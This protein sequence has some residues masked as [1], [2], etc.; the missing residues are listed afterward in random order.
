MV[1][2]SGLVV[3][4]ALLPTAVPGTGSVEAGVAVPMSARSWLAVGQTLDQRV[5]EL[6]SALTLDEEVRL[7]YGVAAPPSSAPAGY[8]RGVERL[9][10]PPLVLSDGPLGLR[11]STRAA[12]R[13]P[14]TALPAGLSLSASFDRSL[15]GAY[16][17]VLGGEARARGVHVLYGPAINIVRH[18]LGGRN[19]EYLGEDPYLAGELAVPYVQG[20]QSHQVAA[21][22]KHFALN[23][24]ENGRHALSS[25]ADERTVREIYLPAF[26]AAVRRGGA[27]SLMCA[28]N[29]IN[30]V[31][32]CE[33]ARLLRDV[34]EGEWGFDGVVGSDYA[35]THSA[36]GSVNAGLDQSFSWRDWGAFYRDLPGLVR[37]GKVARS[38]VDGRVRRIL[39][40]MFRIGMFDPPA[41]VPPVVDV[42]ANLRVARRT[43]EEGMVLLRNDRRLLPLKP[44]ATT[45]IAVIGPYA[46]TAHPGGEGSSQVL[47]R[48]FVP[49]AAGIARR[50]GATIAV[51][52]DTGSDAARA[53]ALA[54]ASDVAVVVVGDKG[55]EG[56]DRAAMSLP[57]DQ[58]A[59]IARVAAANPDTVVVLNTGGPVVMPWLSRVS[60]LIEAWYPGERNGDALAAVLFGDV[61]TSGR[62]P[63]TFP[64]AAA[65]SPA[66]GKPRYPAGSK[67]YDYAEGLR[68]GYRGFDVLKRTPLFPFGFGLSYTTF[69][70]AGLRVTPLPA[71]EGTSLTVRF[72]VTNTGNRPGVEVPQVYLEV[73][74]SA[75]EPP[76]Q[77]KEFTRTVLA[78]GD[79]QVV[80]LAMPPSALRIWSAA[81]GWHTPAGTYRVR[82][83]SS[84]R[85][86]PLSKSV[87]VAGSVAAAP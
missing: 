70:Y 57:A 42:A 8:V 40:M 24:Q 7:M 19:F 65:Q 67:G 37:A 3:A 34:L 68:V 76:R 43:S 81:L 11:D 46:N 16:G 66:V 48:Q 35:A 72:T 4:M 47:G 56:S 15:A 44:A 82:V 10:I 28:N 50:A 21:Q 51:R 58:N 41:A 6:L 79:Q 23:N 62:L 54:K 22:V 12:V 27:W 78:P 52:T 60:T 14:A 61:D 31:Y 36:V 55:Q 84:S 83:G 25:N 13:R 73:P 5:E 17:D 45:S 18:P 2:K 64:T 85:T 9:G 26:E 32:A 39:R 74:S 87:A 59:L 86:L 20:V 71:P 1:V 29:P 69:R 30:G 33:N 49:P 80:T 53:A 75:G 77:L 63:M 38:T